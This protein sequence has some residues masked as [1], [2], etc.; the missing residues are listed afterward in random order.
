[1]AGLSPKLPLVLD[2]EDGYALNK[3]LKDIV[4]QNMKNLMLT[5]PG[6]RIMDLQFGVGIR[7]FLFSHGGDV[8]H[9]LRNKI[10]SQ[11]SNYLPFVEVEDVLFSSASEDPVQENIVEEILYIRLVYRIVP[12]D[13]QE[14]LELSINL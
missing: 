7:N 14:I 3:T 13:V 12:I 6:E 11:V 4:K 8:Q 9:E 1:M 2:K 10:F 5:A